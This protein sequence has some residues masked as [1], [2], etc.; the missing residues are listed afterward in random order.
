MDNV[1][2]ST[3]PQQPQRKVFIQ[4]FGCQMNVYDSSKMLA[5]LRADGFSPTGSADDA[6]LVLI[7]TCSV[8]EKPEHKLHSAIGRLRKLRKTHPFLLGITGCMAQHAGAAL[9]EKYRDV[10]LVIGPDAIPRIRELVESAKTRRVLDNRFLEVADYPFIEDLDPTETAQATGLVTIQKGC[11][12][13]C[14]FCIVP[15]TRGQEASRPHAQIVDEVRRLTEG[16][17]RDITLIGQNV[18]SYGL[19]TGEIPFSELL[20]RVAEVPELLRLRYTTSHPRDMGEDVVQAY[21]DLPNLASHLHLPAQ[22]GSNSVLRRMKRFYTRERYLDVVAQLRDA[23]PDLSITTDLIVGFPGETDADFEQTLDLMRATPF[24]GAFSFRYSARPGTAALRLKDGP[25]DLVAKDRL[26]RLQALQSELSE[27][28]NRQME[29]RTLDVLVEKT[30]R[31]SDAVLAGR[32]SCFRTVNFAGPTEWIGQ[33]VPV[34]VLRGYT[35]SLR[36][37]AAL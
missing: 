7:N 24:D 9:F 3:A 1:V 2:S 33:L 15:M 36:G 5:Q 28:A 18:N 6:D 22:S 16:G 27:R 34:R 8:R 32:T 29:G 11:D 30:S 14:T 10:D 31:N 13:K 26:Q 19:K 37:E 20:Y 25:D 4:T 12:N 21:R 23:R 17:V 35:N